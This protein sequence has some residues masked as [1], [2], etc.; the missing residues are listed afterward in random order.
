MAD[1][2]RR[3]GSVWGELALAVPPT[4]VVLGA[5]FLL[6]TV[7]HQRVLFASL[8]ASAFLI[9]RDPDHPMNGVRV[10]VGAHLIGAGLG[11]AG[12]LIFQPGYPASAVAMIATIILLVLFNLVHPPAIATALGFAFFP[13][14]SDAAGMFL[15]ALVLVAALVLVQSAAVRLVVRIESHYHGHRPSPA[16]GER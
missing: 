7:E 6:E 15:V 4:L 1:G 14:R 9:Y 11:L 16:G 2:T 3:R 10:M 5:V 12:A 13:A 8:A